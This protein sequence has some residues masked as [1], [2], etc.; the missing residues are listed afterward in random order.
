[1][2]SINRARHIDASPEAIFDALSDPN[3][4]AALM[5]RMRQVELKERQAD[6]ARIVT[7]MAIGP[8]ADIRSEG[9]VR[10][11]SGREVIFSSQRPVSIEVRWS[12]T[13]V[14]D[15]T[16][17]KAALSLDL[18]PLIGPLAAF[19]PQKEVD[20]LVGTDLDLALAEI[21]R[22]VEQRQV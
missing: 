16:D 20:N 6:R 4:L 1:M 10:W 7:H 18:A 15:G 3:N 9:D 22:R 14:G 8:F 13:R 12:L 19:V 2:I 21:A 5:P 17:V 11:R